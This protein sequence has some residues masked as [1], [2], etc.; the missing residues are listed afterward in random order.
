MTLFELKKKLQ[1]FFVK[2]H[3]KKKA[4]PANG[5]V[6]PFISIHK[7]KADSSL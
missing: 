6:Q 3:S 1:E 4:K 5:W 7:D 2:T